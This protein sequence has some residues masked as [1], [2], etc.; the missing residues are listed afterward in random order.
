M[1]TFAFIPTILVST[2]AGLA[3][4]EP[5]CSLIGNGKRYSDAE[6]VKAV[7][8]FQML[9]RGQAVR[10]KGR[11]IDLPACNGDNQ[12]SGNCYT[13]NEALFGVNPYGEQI[14]GMLFYK[15]LSDTTKAP[16]QSPTGCQP[17]DPTFGFKDDDSNPT[18]KILLVDRGTCSFVR[19]VRMG[20]VCVSVI[21][22]H[23]KMN[24]SSSS[25]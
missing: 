14:S 23:T 1:K 13:V 9:Y 24:H 2:N 5:S 6:C 20:Q 25:V 11:K 3:I 4:L 22:K 18:R 7:S 19:K 16:G 10:M 12:G 17:L 15:F 21:I 8:A